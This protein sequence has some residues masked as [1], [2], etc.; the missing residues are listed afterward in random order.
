MPEPPA[1]D[2]RRIRITL[3][4]L[5]SSRDLDGNLQAALRVVEAAAGAG[6][7]L[8]VLPENCLFCGANAEMRGT[9][10]RIDAAPIATLRRAAAG[11]ATPVILG[12]FKRLTDSGAIYNTALVIGPDGEIAAA[13]DKIHLFDAA[14]GGIA[15]EASSVERPG[16]APLIVTLSGVRLGLTIC[17]DVRFPELYRNLALAGAEVFL[18]PSAFT[19]ITGAAHWESLLR[20]RAIENGAFVLASATIGGT[21]LPGPDPT[22]TYGHALA[23]DPWGGIMADL[24]EDAGVWR[25]LTLSLDRVAEARRKLP[26]LRHTRPAAGKTPREAILDGRAGPIA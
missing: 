14:I 18:V 10:F 22:A 7:D 26:V 19:R 2:Q 25:T 20:A 17:Y 5:P 24:G 21:G 8:I 4:Q 3:T 13:Y 16:E 15:Y 1:S 11:G 9:A 12:G 6:T 23:V